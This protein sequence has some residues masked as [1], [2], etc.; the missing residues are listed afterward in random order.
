MKVFV[1]LRQKLCMFRQTENVWTQLCLG[2]LSISNV[3]F[4]SH[5]RYSTICKEFFSYELSG[6]PPKHQVLEHQLRNNQLL[7]HQLSKT[8][9]V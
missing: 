3:A 1:F 2:L 4:E 7:K 9:T 8:S 6:A 5:S